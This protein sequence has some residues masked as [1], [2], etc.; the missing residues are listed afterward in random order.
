ME[1]KTDII[2]NFQQ[3]V[4]DLINGKVGKNIKLEF[5]ELKT[6]VL[7]RLK[8]KKEIT[9]AGEPF[10]Y[11]ANAEKHTEQNFNQID[12]LINNEPPKPSIREQIKNSAKEHGEKKEPSKAPHKSEPEL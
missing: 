11:L 5:E 10:N 4:T 2:E 12:G 6:G 1:N 3:Y 7:S 8:C 9:F